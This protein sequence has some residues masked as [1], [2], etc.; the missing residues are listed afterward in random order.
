MRAGGEGYGKN[1]EPGEKGKWEAT[2]AGVVC[3][4]GLRAGKKE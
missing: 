4:V 1:V 2:L 3:V